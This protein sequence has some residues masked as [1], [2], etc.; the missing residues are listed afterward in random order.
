MV[1]SP[2]APGTA[3]PLHVG[4]LALPKMTQLDFTGP[5]EV[6][7]R[8]PNT[9]VHVVWKRPG[10]VETDRGLKIYADTAIAECPQLDIVFVPGGPGQSLVAEDSEVLEFVRMQASGAR[11]VTSVCTGA[12]V[13]GAAGLLEGHRATTHWAA[14]HVLPSYG[15]TPSDGRVV[16]DGNLVTGG[17]VTAGI[18]FALT[19]AAEIFGP[20][21]AQ[22]IQLQI[23]Y[24]PKPPFN[25]GTPETAPS[26]I[27]AALRER[28]RPLT[29]T[30]EA[31]AKQYR[32]NDARR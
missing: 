7:A 2:S 3:N 21:V 9:I 18:D 28:M 8:F 15:A 11:Y 16:V 29:E 12:L 27:V 25:A 23:E 6:F 17:G 1:S 24:S 14:K 20:E 19:L 13:L 10:P 30:R 32:A 5:F 26:A 31:Q 4:M 22:Q